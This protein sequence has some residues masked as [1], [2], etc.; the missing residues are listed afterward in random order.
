MKSRFC[1]YLLFLCFLLGG[2]SS[3]HSAFLND[4]SCELPCWRTI[5]IGKTTKEQVQNALDQMDD[6]QENSINESP[7]F[8]DTF[9]NFIYWNFKDVI[10]SQG[11]INFR[12]NIAIAL[13]F[14]Y[15]PGMSL[16]NFVD[17]LGYPDELL[18]IALHGDPMTYVTLYLVYPDKEVCLLHDKSILVLPEDVIVEIGE[19]TPIKL[20]TLTDKQRTNPQHI[21]GCL[22]GMEPEFYDTHVQK[23]RG[24]G[25]YRVIK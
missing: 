22:R 1:V 20:F 16:K 23:W 24:Y 9:D 11:E 4:T 14:Q 5:T 25:E 2:C 8:N 10:E 15:D 21:V 3:T 19:E 17:K 7:T 12:D 13:S 18:I 6:I